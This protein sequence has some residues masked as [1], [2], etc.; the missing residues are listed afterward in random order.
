VI[1]YSCNVALCDQ[2]LA[3]SAIPVIV[4]HKTNFVRSKGGLAFLRGVAQFLFVE[5]CSLAT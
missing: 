1:S 3:T 4:L 2:L 5:R